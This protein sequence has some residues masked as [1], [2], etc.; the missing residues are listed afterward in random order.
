MTSGKQPIAPG[1]PS[2]RS[3]SGDG[4]EKRSVERGDGLCL[5]VFLLLSVTPYVGSLGF[6]SDDWAF[7]ARAQAPGSTLAGT[8]DALWSLSRMR[9]VGELSKALQ[10]R[11][12]GATP[13]GYH[14][15]N[16]LVLV[17]IAL[18][19]WR[20]LRELRVPRDAALA[21]ALL[22]GVLPHFS[23]L[24]FWFSSGI[25]NISLALFFV[26]A[27]ADLRA[28]RR[29]SA[30][31][32]ALRLASVACTVASVLTY[33][34]VVP[35][36]VA[37]AL[38]GG[39]WMRRAGVA[40][41]ATPARLWGYLAALVPLILF[42]A[43][44]PD[45]LGGFG[46]YGPELLR[47]VGH[48]L[49]TP[50]YAP[51]DSGLNLLALARFH[52]LTY[53]LLLPASA[54]KIVHLRFAPAILV[55][56]VALG[57]LAALAVARARREESGDRAPAS[58][59]AL[60]VV[61]FA[62]GYLIFLTNGNIQVSPTGTGNRT[63]GVAG[64]GVA[65]V[66]AGLLRGAKG[67]GPAGQLSSPTFAILLGAAV[68]LF[69][70]VTGSLAML[71]V[72]AYAEQRR[73]LAQIEQDVGALPKG[74]TLFVDGACRY[75]G[76]APVFEAPW[77]LSGA[78]KILYREPSLRADM[79]IPRVRVRSDGVE[80]AEYD[81]PTIYPYERLFVYDAARR[82]TF[83]LPD[84]ASAELYFARSARDSEKACPPGFGG[85]GAA[86]F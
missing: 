21:S 50:G 17:T 25:A 49:F 80:T 65:L 37:W 61:V 57:T 16:T 39:R 10:L 54:W 77:D 24:R 12:F 35:L 22:Y 52:G 1:T 51:G 47:W 31:R 45:R 32:G 36:F 18:L 5:L 14:A 48:A 71:W 62:L 68:S 3:E 9:P 59:V 64:L 27:L 20:L 63:A 15:V 2:L 58:L 33:E 81:S 86:V 23:T 76:P 56:A 75:V 67:I 7:L 85:W 66:I 44:V 69:Y 73:I 46:G 70:L 53:G 34:L 29:S 74:A 79:A 78:L 19:F 55:T 26:A 28:T 30:A 6:Y 83:P 72:D 41:R 84:R 4:T 38:F 40:P 43:S 82:A 13:F 42:K 8:F 60:G 11:V